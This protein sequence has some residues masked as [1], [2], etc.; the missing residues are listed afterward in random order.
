MS[1][2]NEAPGILR[3]IDHG[4]EMRCQFSI[5]L[6][7]RKIFLV[8]T[9]DGD[10]NFVRQVQEGGIEV[11]VNYRRQFVE[12]RHQLQQVGIFV[13]AVASLLRMTSKFAF[14]LF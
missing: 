6:L 13:N 11:T 9:H 3:Q 12:V 7:D 8:T 1:G 5:A 4:E 14:D 2:T 10:Q